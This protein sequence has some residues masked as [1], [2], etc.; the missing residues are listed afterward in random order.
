MTIE[1]E[2]KAALT[3]DGKLLNARIKGGNFNPQTIIR[4]VFS[5]N[6]DALYPDGSKGYITAYF[7]A[8]HKYTG[9]RTHFRAIAK[10]P[11]SGKLKDLIFDLGIAEIIPRDFEVPK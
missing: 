6:F 2:I 1:D 11:E 4:D 9:L 3:P 5:L 7:V 10:V 8:M